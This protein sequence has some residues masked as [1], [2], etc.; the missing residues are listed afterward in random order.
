MLKWASHKLLKRTWQ[1]PGF[2]LFFLALLLRSW[3]D[4]KT[5]VARGYGIY[6]C[7]TNPGSFPGVI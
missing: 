6:R 7:F 4:E 1:T 3:P 2:P 5:P